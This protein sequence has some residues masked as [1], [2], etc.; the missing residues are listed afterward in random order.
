VAE[1]K[2]GIATYYI[3][4]NGSFDVA[5]AQLRSQVDAGL[6]V[7]IRRLDGLQVRVSIVPS[8]A[9][10][11]PDVPYWLKHA[12]VRCDLCSTSWKGGYVGVDV[13]GTIQASVCFDCADV[14]LRLQLGVTRLVMS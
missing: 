7:N 12:S 11:P 3:D 9:D 5:I 6:P 10:A 13:S 2:H 8:P 4:D 1:R 14:L